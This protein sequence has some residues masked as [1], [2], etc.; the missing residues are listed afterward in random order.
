MKEK[1][2]ITCA[3]PYIN[4]V[5]HLGHIA[6]C[7]LPADVFYRFNKNIGNDVVLVGGADSHGTATLIGA[8]EV[9]LSPDEF[10]EKLTNIHRDIYKKIGISYDLFSS[11]KTEV[12]K[13]NTLEFFDI[14][15]KNPS[16][17]SI[18]ASFIW[19]SMIK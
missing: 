9:S 13:K 14:L 10:V 6:G 19:S 8:K 11:T 4:N 12:H 2:L 17:V 7:H 3:L 5:P 15:N 16:F 18:K 1:I